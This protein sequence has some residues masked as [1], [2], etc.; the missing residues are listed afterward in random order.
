M[1]A[2]GGQEVSRFIAPDP[3]LR[4][5]IPALFRVLSS[6]CLIFL[7]MGLVM[8]VERNNLYCY[9]AKSSARRNCDCQN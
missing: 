4:L 5:L 6:L 9:E 7:S 1:T 3:G 8:V 2:A